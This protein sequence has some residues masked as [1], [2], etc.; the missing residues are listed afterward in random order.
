MQKLVVAIN[1]SP[2]ITVVAGSTATTSSGEIQHAEFSKKRADKVK[3]KLV[4]LGAD[5]SK[6]VS[7][8]I[9]KSYKKYRVPDTD[10][11]DNESNKAKN[12]CVFIVSATTERAQ[13]FLSIAEKF[14][15]NK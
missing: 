11:F 9:G 4:S 6:L 2:D 14:E 7:V 10:E 15:I 8:G 3:D 13:Y 5:E 12:R 1:S